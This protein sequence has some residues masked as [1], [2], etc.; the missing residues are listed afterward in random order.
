MKKSLIRININFTFNGKEHNYK[1]QANQFYPTFESMYTVYLGLQDF[2][3]DWY[4][5]P[6][7]EMSVIQIIKVMKIQTII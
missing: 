6:V 3:D 1:I 5:S 7:V 2:S 4:K